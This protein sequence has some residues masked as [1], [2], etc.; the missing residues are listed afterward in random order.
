MT[1]DTNDAADGYGLTS[2]G[3]PW[4]EITWLEAQ[5]M[6]NDG[7]GIDSI[8]EMFDKLRPRTRFGCLSDAHN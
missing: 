5:E 4:G 3:R 8:K 2:D 1:S 7:T 6:V